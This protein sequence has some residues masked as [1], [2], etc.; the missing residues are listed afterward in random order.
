MKLKIIQGFELQPAT[1]GRQVF[2]PQLLVD[3]AGLD[4]APASREKKRVNDHQEPKLAFGSGL[5]QHIGT[6]G[7]PCSGVKQ[8][9][10]T[11]DY[12]CQALEVG[13]LLRFEMP[14]QR[15]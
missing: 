7:D 3:L 8:P 15:E 1:L 13:L 12:P 6:Y 11:H 5:R 14:G 9:A 4:I 10:H 2:S